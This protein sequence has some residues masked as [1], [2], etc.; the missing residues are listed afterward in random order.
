M[1]RYETEFSIININN[2][3]SPRDHNVRD[4]IIAIVENFFQENQDVMLYICE[5]GDG[6]QSMRRRLFGKGIYGYNYTLKQQTIKIN[7][8]DFAPQTIS[9]WARYNEILSR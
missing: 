1:K 6:K 8:Y 9:L 5:T 7:Y 3:R 2:K 4:T